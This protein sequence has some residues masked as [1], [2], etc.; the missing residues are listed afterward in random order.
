M[1]ARF[2]LNVTADIKKAER[3]LS[4][5]EKKVLP[6]AAATALNKTAEEVRTSTVKELSKEI[7]G[8][9]GLKQTGIK[10]LIEILKASPSN[11]I[12]VLIPSG[13]RPK[14]INFI[15]VKQIAQG[16]AA[17]IKGKRVLHQGAFIAT[18][19][20]GHKGVF[21]RR[22]D[23]KSTRRDSRGRRFNVPHGLKIKE[24][25]GPSIPM[26]FIKGVILESMKAKAK[27]VW[28][29]KF[30]QNLRFYLSMAGKT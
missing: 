20:S 17:R 29:K 9:V 22:S 14:L 3:Y 5:I 25:T 21:V 6:R 30:A 7:G 13:K 2:E 8:E 10:R 23:T 4:D 18:M 11:L 15:G 12:A 19:P 1:A 27:D 16:V 28:P 24:L 26:Y